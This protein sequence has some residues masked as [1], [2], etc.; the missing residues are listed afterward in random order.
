MAREDN[1]RLDA[2]V[3]EARP[4]SGYY[5]RS[6]HRGQ[7]IKTVPAAGLIPRPRRIALSSM[8]NSIVS[9]IANPQLLPLGMSVLDTALMPHKHLHRIMKDLIERGFIEADDPT[10]LRDEFI[11]LLTSELMIEDKL[12]DEVEELVVLDEL[13]EEDGA[14]AAELGDELT[15]VQGLLDQA[16]LGHLV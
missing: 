6:S 15:R 14:L 4:K 3:V 5:V 9:A 1:L 2:K 13:A 10:K 7:R 12:N 11:R 8:I 16:E